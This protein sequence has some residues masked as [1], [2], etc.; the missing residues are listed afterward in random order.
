MTRGISRTSLHVAAGRAVGALEPDPSVRNPDFLAQTLLGDPSKLHFDLPILRALSLPYEEAMKDPA[1]AHHVQMMMIRTRFIDDA[2]A[3][4]IA[5]GA[6]Q[7]VVLGA[8]LD[9]RAYRC[10]DLLRGTRI[11]E[12]DHV[13]TQELKRQRVR[14]TVAHLPENLTY[15]AID[16]LRDDLAGVLRRSGCD[17]TQRTFFVLEGVSMYLSEEALRGALQVVASHP[18]GSGIVFDFIY[19]SVIDGL[20]DVDPAGVPEPFRTRMRDFWELI[21]NEPWVFGMPARGE[22]EYLSA[23]GLDLDEVLPMG[24]EKSIQRYATKADGTQVGAQA[25]AATKVSETVRGHASG[26]SPP[27]QGRVSLERIRELRDAGVGAPQLATAAVP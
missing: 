18:A 25:F 5:A 11:F 4:A 24:G 1:I 26:S 17:P 22:R 2:L 10:R 27:R 13:A 12:V 6:A 20:R 3:R 16:F 15:V 23:L 9:S 7:V 19:R 14:A 21:K 8:G